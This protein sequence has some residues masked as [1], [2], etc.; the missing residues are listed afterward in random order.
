MQTGTLLVITDSSYMK[1]LSTKHAVAAW[2]MECPRTGTQ[3]HGV[4]QVLS[5]EEDIN[6]FRA[7]LTE[8]ITVRK[9]LE[10]IAKWWQVTAATVALRVDNRGAGFTA[11]QVRRRISQMNKHVDLIRKMRHIN[12]TSSIKV[13]FEHVYG[14]QD[15]DAAFENIPR[16]AQLN[17][18]CDWEAKSYLRNLISIA[19]P[20]PPWRPE[21]TWG[22]WIRG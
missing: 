2:V 18:I 14:H 15:E 8:P 17:V 10:F 5:E 9:G 12:S 20:T 19:T 22:C 3:C 1:E 6:P 21:H 4:I 11:C 13:I 7:K 16:P